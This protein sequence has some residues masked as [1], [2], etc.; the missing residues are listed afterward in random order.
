MR[1]HAHTSA[2]LSAGT[3]PYLSSSE[4][5]A[6]DARSHRRT[7]RCCPPPMTVAVR[8]AGVEM[9]ADAV[10]NLPP[11]HAD[12]RR[13]KQ[14]LLN[15]VGNAVKFTA[16]GSVTMRVRPD[17][18]APNDR[19]RF[20]V[21]DTGPGVSEQDRAYIFS[22]EQ[23]AYFG[24]GSGLGLLLCRR[25]LALMGSSLHG[26]L[27]TPHSQRTMHVRSPRRH[28]R[29]PHMCLSLVQASRPTGDAAELVAPHAALLE[30]LVN[31]LSEEE[32]EEL[33]AG[34]S[35]PERE[36]ALLL[37]AA[38]RV[39][40]NKELGQTDRSDAGALVEELT[41]REKHARAGDAA[42][43]AAKKF[44]ERAHRLGYPSL[45]LLASHAAYEAVPNRTVKE[46]RSQE[47]HAALEKDALKQARNVVHQNECLSSA[48]AARAVVLSDPD[49]DSAATVLV[50]KHVN[51]YS[52]ATTTYYV[53]CRGSTLKLKDW[54]YN[55]DAAC[56]RVSDDD[57]RKAFRG[58][59]MHKGFFALS[60]RLRER[61]LPVLL[62]ILQR[63]NDGPVEVVFCGHSL[64]GA[65]A[66]LLAADLADEFGLGRPA[67]DGKPPAA[68]SVRVV[69]FGC[70]RLGD[71]ELTRCIEK[72]V[73]HVRVHHSGDPVPAVP[74]QAL[75]AASLSETDLAPYG[76]H[77]ATR[78][79]RVSG[80]GRA[81]KSDTSQ[82]VMDRVFTSHFSQP[83]S[84]RL[85]M[86]GRFGSVAYLASRCHKLE[87]YMSA[88]S[89]DLDNGSI[90][91]AENEK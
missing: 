86:L 32:R 36:E 67:G 88:F 30:L 31:A 76:S 44:K 20:E 16:A 81:A 85:R 66:V 87:C 38:R 2:S 12:A 59:S 46:L 57:V 79:V 58:T 71:A 19:V 18:A 11:A 90:W 51:G 54:A 55:T 53:A 60:F 63:R 47:D 64:G 3:K 1:P 77:G 10:P 39:K 8:K 15:L 41:G 34:A 72:R 78:H 75:R 49:L 89:G 4:A 83:F 28:F 52:S 21:A 62:D 45:A 73:E 68:A 56:V 70:P 6:R 50:L 22:E 29:I 65:M 17:P 24:S 26:L 5:A 25:F 82:P 84:S 48:F 9:L 43:M 37:E 42:D 80:F 13:L 69:T 40:E 33:D 23:M 61:L 7:R 35:G 91:P 27:S 14:V 74:C